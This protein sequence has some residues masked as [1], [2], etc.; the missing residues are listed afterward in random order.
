MKM[1][2]AEVLFHDVP[3]F[4]DGLVPFYLQKGQ[5]RSPRGLSH[6][7]VLDLVQAEKL[8]ILFTKITLVGK[9][10]LDRI[11]GVATAGNAQG[12]EGAVVER[13]GGHF[14]GQDKSVAG[15][16]GNMLF[17]TEMWL[18]VLDRPVGI[19]IAGK[20]HR[21]AVLIQAALRRFSF[22]PFFFEF[23]LAE[24]MTGRLYQAGIDGDA[25]IDG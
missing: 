25:F 4:G 3:D 10:L 14:R 16:H 6:D 15:V 19:E 12:K 21:L 17:Q 11:L 18:V 7:A 20:L 5:L 23:V 13:G 1:A 22:G 8:A 2:D 9:D 24:G